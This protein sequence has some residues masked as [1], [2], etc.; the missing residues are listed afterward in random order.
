MEDQFTTFQNPTPVP[1][2]VAAQPIRPAAGPLTA[3]R[4]EPPADSSVPG[5][6]GGESRNSRLSQR[7]GSASSAPLAVRW[8]ADLTPTLRPFV[9]LASGN[10]VVL[11]GATQWALCDRAGRVL[12]VAPL[13]PSPVALDP[14]RSLAFA[15]DPFGRIVA[16]SLADGQAVFSALL[17][18]G[19]SFTHPFLALRDRL[20]VTVG[21]EIPVDPS[22]PSPERSI[23]EVTDLG[24]PASR[25]SWDEPGG[26]AVIHD[27]IRDS[28]RMLA[29]L[30]G[31][32]LV[33][34]VP[35]RVYLLDLSLKAR[36]AMG[37]VF[38]PLALSLD[39]AGR[40]YLLV[41][42]GGRSALWL[43]TPEGERIYE[44]EL[45][46]GLRGLIHPP[47]VG[48]DHT[49]FVRAERQ[50]LSI[51]PDGKVNWI[52]TADEPLA[53]AAITPDDFLL[54]SEGSSLAAWDAKGERRVL[55]TFAGEN[56]TTAPVLTAD[57]E[58]LVATRTHLYCL[59]P[60]GGPR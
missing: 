34:A 46:P 32:T 60:R 58:I 12:D 19:K 1:F 31:D 16:H 20:M 29:A 47:I 25:R 14:A 59:A 18:F 13:G 23:V 24:D 5:A 33:L 2:A 43:L 44:C 36:R 30:A 40:I 9:L 35:N 39:E 51:A 7:L 57:G 54:T 27:L 26:P 37:G 28:R 55:H 45:P 17:Y 53:G 6:Y 42:A 15:A 4:I 3:A 52:R 49:V 10:R 21:I 22:M 48:Y 38:L 8:R 50:I 56:P 11:H 41:A